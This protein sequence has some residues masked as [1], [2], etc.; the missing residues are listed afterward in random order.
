M[1]VSV[2]F[3]VVFIAYASSLPV[4]EEEDVPRTYYP[5]EDDPWR[6]RYIIVRDDNGQY[7]IEDLWADPGESRAT[8]S[9]L[10]FYLYTQNNQNS[11]NIIPANNFNAIS[12]SQFQAS[13][14][15]VF[16][17]HGWNNH[18]NSPVNQVIRAAVLRN[19][20]VNLFVID[21]SR[22]A[23]QF[24][25]T[26]RNAVPV[27]GR[28]VGEFINRM[29]STFNLRPANFDLVGHSLGAHLVGVAGKNIQGLAN[30][31][32]GLDPAGPLYTVANTAERIHHADGDHVQIIHTNSG[33]LGF[34]S[35]IGDVDYH[36]NGGRSQ[37][38]CGLDL[39]G[40]CAHSRAYDFYGESVLSSNFF[41]RSCGAHNDYTA[42]RCN[43]NHRSF[44]G[45]LNVD[46]SARGDHRLVTN[47]NSPFA[48]G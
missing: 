32:V 34:G 46:K 33:L 19:N 2:I 42:G 31:I 21:W 16:V 1:K 6:Q 23:N 28:L 5:E 10:T 27:M 41:S 12:N 30:S 8:I 14:R 11:P 43:N 45:T 22:P 26:A 29:M 9:D 13:R 17:S 48:R 18:F 35:S 37:P 38:G 44:M 4:G 3:L 20:N 7:H 25:T 47:S 39:V 36:P 24:Y 15:N 40:T